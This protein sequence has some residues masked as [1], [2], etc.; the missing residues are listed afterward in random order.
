MPL[1]WSRINAGYP[2]NQWQEWPTSFIHF[3]LAGSTAI[4]YFNPAADAFRLRDALVP[5]PANYAFRRPARDQVPL[6]G[7]WAGRGGD[8]NPRTGWFHLRNSLTASYMFRFG[9]K[10]MIP[11]AGNWDGQ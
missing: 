4:G 7:R 6:V 5:G 9:P 2:A 8:N 11:L 10:H 3:P 1:T